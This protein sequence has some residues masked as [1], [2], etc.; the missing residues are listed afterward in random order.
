M[1]HCKL[2]FTAVVRDGDRKKNR[3]L[4]VDMHEVDPAK[5]SK[6]SQ[7]EPPT[8]RGD[9]YIF[10]SGPRAAAGFSTPPTSCGLLGSGSMIR[11]TRFTSKS[12]IEYFRGAWLFT[13][14]IQV[15]CNQVF[16]RGL[17]PRILQSGR[18]FSTFIFPTLN[19]S[20]VYLFGTG[21]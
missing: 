10:P 13:R 14:T 18:S 7:P 5:R 20:F 6:S 2:Q 21:R 15:G 11:P 3:V 16:S 19:R 1:N 12:N 4:V 9:K 17:H 8:K